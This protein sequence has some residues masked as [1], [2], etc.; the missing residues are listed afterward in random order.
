MFHGAVYNLGN[1]DGESM[2]GNGGDADCAGGGL[3][4]AGSVEGRSQGDRHV[5]LRA[6]GHGGDFVDV[7]RAVG[8]EW[9]GVL[10]MKGDGSGA[11]LNLKM[12]K[13]TYGPM[14]V[15]PNWPAGPTVE[16]L[17]LQAYLSTG[18]WLVLAEGYLP[19]ELSPLALPM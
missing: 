18:D 4:C 7:P 6:L 13:F 10:Q 1:D 15:W 3:A 12:A 2:E 5:V 17:A 19:K 9:S 16:V 14:H 11:S 8:A